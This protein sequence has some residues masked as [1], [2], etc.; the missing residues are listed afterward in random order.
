MTSPL[1][2]RGPIPD[3]VA[4][5]VPA[6]DEQDGILGCLAAISDAAAVLVES[7]PG[8]TIEVLVV[9]DRCTDATAELARSAAVRVITT[10]VGRVGGARRAGFIDLLAGADPART[11]LATTDADSTV[12][13]SWLIGQ[14]DLAAAGA[15]MVLGMVQPTGL[16]AWAEAVWLA[17]HRFEDAHGHVFG[18][19]L[20]V[21]ADTYLACGGFPDKP[22]GEDVALV[23]NVAAAGGL[24]VAV[25]G[26]PV[27]TAGRLYGRVDAQ[28][29]AGF[30]GY[31]RTLVGAG[32]F[33]VPATSLAS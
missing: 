13:K 28:E 30:A 32:P 18:A 16:P 8:V 27:L 17:R 11:W 14:F 25:G 9:A 15:D 7:R 24:V 3:R 22:V 33:A 31:L 1:P 6:R 2:W 12:P 20:G 29:P 26:A 19:N 4:V 10:E 5:V 21:R 23:A